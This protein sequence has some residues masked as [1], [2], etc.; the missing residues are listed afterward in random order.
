MLTQYVFQIQHT[1]DMLTRMVDVVRPEQY[2][3]ALEE[4][5]FTLKEVIAHLSDWEVIF[6]DRITMAVEYPG[7]TIEAYDENARAI[8]HKYNSKEIHHELEVLGNRR[9]DTVD[10]ILRLAVDD[11]EKSIIHP[12]RGEMSVLDL[13]NFIIG[14]D[15]YHL[16]QASL[17]MK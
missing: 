16:H 13:V 3:E 5:R 6:L 14:H 2:D 7:S 8:E 9:R 12:D 1:P 4:G 10:Y 15:L 17:Y 11:W